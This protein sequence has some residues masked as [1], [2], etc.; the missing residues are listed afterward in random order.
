MQTLYSFIHKHFRQFL[1]HEGVRQINAD[2]VELTELQN[3]N[4]TNVDI[5]VFITRN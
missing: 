4:T 3:I 5:F 2:I 1:V